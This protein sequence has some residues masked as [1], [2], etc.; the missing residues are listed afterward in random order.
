M[1]FPTEMFPVLFAIG[2]MPGWLAQW[3]EGHN[4]PE[5]RIARPRQL[6]VGHHERHVP[7]AAERG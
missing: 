6:Y 3:E 1:G 4:D 5:Q 2:R 7:L